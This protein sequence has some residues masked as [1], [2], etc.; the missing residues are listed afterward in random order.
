MEDLIAEG[1]R[2]LLEGDNDRAAGYELLAEKV[3]ETYESKTQKSGAPDRIPLPT[4]DTVKHEVLNEL[5]NTDPE[6]AI[7]DYAARAALRS[8]LGLGPEP[9]S[10]PPTNAPPVSQ[11]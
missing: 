7:L 2:S 1:Y 4:I 9:P 6:K 3:R 10:T 11:K 5:L 8:Q